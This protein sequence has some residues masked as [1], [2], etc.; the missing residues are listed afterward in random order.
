ML[1]GWFF[2]CF[3]EIRKTTFIIMS[4][5][6]HPASRFISPSND[7]NRSGG[8]GTLN[9][10]VMSNMSQLANRTSNRIFQV[11]S[12]SP[13]SSE[14]LCSSFYRRSGTPFTFTSNIG[15]P[16]FR[17]RLIQLGH[18]IMPLIPNINRS[19][20][21][22]CFQLIISD[23]NSTTESQPVNIEITLDLG[24]YTPDS[25][26]NELVDKL[27]TGII[28]QAPGQRYNQLFTI[29]SIEELAVTGG[30][31]YQKM[32]YSLSIA[33]TRMIVQQLGQAAGL[34]VST[35]S[36]FDWWMPNDCSFI[37]RGKNVVDFP[38]ADRQ[39]L[40]NEADP[41]NGVYTVPEWTKP[42]PPAFVKR[43][44]MLNSLIGP[45]FIYSRYVTISSEALS[46]YAYGD[47]RVDRTGQTGAEGRN[48]TS[49]GGG[50]GKIIGVLSTAG[51]ASV[52]QDFSGSNR[53]SA[54]NAPAIG[55]KNSQLK[56]NEFI[57]FQ[58]ID[59]FGLPLDNAFPAD[60]NWGP[61]LAFIVGY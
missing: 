39:P 21:Q 43:D 49:A 27:T 5:I 26:H 50:G 42:T 52:G 4:G 3:P 60:N 14:L 53:I 17:P 58:I 32:R 24:Y 15:G 40:Q 48:I 13:E 61:T 46:L 37:Q 18:V 19:N 45:S 54:V 9:V 12:E 36:F 59:E 29:V 30:Y 7:Y 22:F 31:D 57:D 41:S 47:S 28:D 20:N 55:I 34:I 35:T 1:G 6:S 51:Y 25:F 2:F 11:A 33:V 23:S 38:D 8:E 16:L 56:L 44:E 10:N